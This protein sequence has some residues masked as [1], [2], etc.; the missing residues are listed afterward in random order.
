MTKILGGQVSYE[1]GI[2]SA[3]E[4]APPRKVRVELHFEIAEDEQEQADARIHAV[5]NLAQ[6]EVLRLL[7][8]TVA[9]KEEPLSGAALA[10]VENPGQTTRRPRRTQA[11]IAADEAAATEAARLAALEAGRQGKPG[12][13]GD[14]A[15][16]GA[17][18]TS[19]VQTAGDPAG[20]DF[21]SDP[22]KTEISDTSLND[23]CQAKAS[24][25]GSAEKIKA[26]IGTFATDP[27]K[28]FSLREIPQAQRPDFLAKLEA[29]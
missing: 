4:Y 20:F 29:L 14:P 8:Q 25:L 26:L 5:G 7:G 28:Q 16:F 21:T 22:A 6:A 1:D 27:T 17:E 11:Q 18:A 15:A 2:K 24:K 23:A 19:Q 13:A 9:A 3:V 12:D 10:L